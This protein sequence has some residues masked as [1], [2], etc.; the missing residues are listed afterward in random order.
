MRSI[1]L[2]RGDRLIARRIDPLGLLIVLRADHDHARFGLRAGPG[3]TRRSQALGGGGDH[4][5]GR[6]RCGRILRSA[7]GDER[8][9]RRCLLRAQGAGDQPG[10]GDS[11]WPGLVQHPVPV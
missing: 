2:S 3:H 7:A 5:L 6:D 9:L 11:D 1:S 8:H 10:Q 4:V